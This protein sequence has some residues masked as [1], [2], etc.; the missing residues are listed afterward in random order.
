L[1]AVSRA[2][3]A[4]F[5]VGAVAVT[6]LAFLRGVS[7]K[8]FTIAGIGACA[9][10]AAGMLA[11]DSLMARVHED[12]SREN[13]EDLR[14]ILNRQSKAMLHDSPLGIGWNNFGVANSL[15]NEKYV[16]ILM[17]WDVSRGFRIIE[18]NYFAGPLTESLYWLLLSETGYQGFISYL[19]FLALTLWWAARGLIRHWK[20]P[21]GYFIGGVLVALA[22]TYLHGS[23]ERCLSQTKNLSAW[24]IFAG[25]MA[26]V[27]VMRRSSPATFT[28]KQNP[29]VIALPAFA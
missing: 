1:L 6:G 9:A 10:V 29:P 23:V 19:A 26:R 25:F 5:V 11:L 4:A 3:L 22:L 17:D 27:E 13:E 16:T 21:L 24:L 15:P 28:V 7:L 14:P 20:T 2:G 12:A 8:K 18:D